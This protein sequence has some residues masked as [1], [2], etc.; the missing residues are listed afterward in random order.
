VKD[1]YLNMDFIFDDENVADLNPEKHLY[2]WIQY[3]RLNCQQ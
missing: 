1:G 3:L 2:Q